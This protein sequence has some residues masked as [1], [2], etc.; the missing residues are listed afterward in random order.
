[1]AIDLFV[2]VTDVFELYVLQGCKSINE[3]MERTAAY[4]TLHPDKPWVV[5]R[6]WE[7]DLMER[8]P[9]KE[10]LDSACA[11]RPVALFRVCGHVVVVN[12]LALSRAG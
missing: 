8:Y 10:D 12:S 1:M 9:A 4:A 11:D 6:G 7:Q 3:L 5:G 2:N